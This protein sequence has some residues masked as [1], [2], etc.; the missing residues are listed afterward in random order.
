[1]KAGA[2]GRAILEVV[3]VPGTT[4]ELAQPV[5][6]EEASWNAMRWAYETSKHIIFRVT[7]V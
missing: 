1:M 5:S 4:Q 2:L 6:V 3:T 7:T